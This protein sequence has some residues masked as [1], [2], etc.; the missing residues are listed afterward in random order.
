MKGFGLS[1]K[2]FSYST[3]CLPV[4]FQIECLVNVRVYLSMKLPTRIRKE[5]RSPTVGIKGS[6]STLLD[7]K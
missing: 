7:S 4:C 6:L 2:L 1:G 3:L 5:T